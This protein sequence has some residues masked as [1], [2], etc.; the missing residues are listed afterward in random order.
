MH[1]RIL[2]VA[3][4]CLCALP[5]FAQSS[6]QARI[7][8]YRPDSQYA[9][10]GLHAW[11]NTTDNVTWTSPIQSDG[12]DSY[13]IYFDVDLADSTT[14]LGFIIHKGDTK[15]PGPD[16]YLSLIHIWPAW[17]RLSPRIAPQRSHRASS[18]DLIAIRA[19]SS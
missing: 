12:S 18:L 15:D 8:Y 2:L 1:R 19:M 10:W 4:L 3:L 9:G 14:D 13:G 6:T 11:N 16:M 7:H 5:L 17:R